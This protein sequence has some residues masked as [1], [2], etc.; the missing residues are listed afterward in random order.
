VIICYKSNIYNLEKNLLSYV[1]NIDSTGYTCQKKRTNIQGGS[2]GNVN[3]LNG[4]NTG[5]YEKRKGYIIICLI[6]L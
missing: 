4:D 5:R 1:F 6:N 2:E 3:I